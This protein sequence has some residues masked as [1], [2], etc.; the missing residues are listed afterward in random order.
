MKLKILV[1]GGS[2]YFG[3]V[4][5]RV[6]LDQGLSV[7]GVDENAFPG[8][9][10]TNPAF[11][12]TQGQVEDAG[13]MRSLLKDADA[14]FPLAALVG[15]SICDQNPDKAKRVNYEAIKL[16]GRLRSREQRIIFPMTNA[17]YVRPRSGDVCDEDSPMKPLTLYAQTKRDAESLLLDSGGVIS[18]RMA[19]LLGA[20]FNMRWDLLVH[21]F[22]KTAFSEK[23]LVLY[24]PHAKRN[25]LHVR[26]AADGFL[27]CLSKWEALK[28]KPYNLGYEAANLTKMEIVKKIQ[29]F[30]PEL[31]IISA[32]EGQDP[33]GRDFFISGERLRK[34]GFEAH[35]TLEQG[36]EEA[37]DYLRKHLC[38][39]V[40]V[41]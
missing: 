24:E 22:L 32:K 5:I 33:E 14:I 31:E 25:F 6:L 35:R 10:I 9:R 38:E 30:L 1:T 26:D 36:I 8:P 20:S 21:H 23:R 41:K 4:L 37:L 29:S 13:L 40:S 3:S 34:A 16:L 17:G 12:F 11:K 18:L 7:Q 27:F 15:S 39:P 28:D 2:G 19:S